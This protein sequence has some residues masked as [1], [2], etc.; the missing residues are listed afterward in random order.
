M[1][2]EQ[3]L[4]GA[5]IV[6]VILGAVLLIIGLVGYMRGEPATSEFVSGAL[7]IVIGGLCFQV[8]RRK[9]VARE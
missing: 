2:N 3:V 7:A 9:Q 8:S 6:A 1:T 4:R 5:S